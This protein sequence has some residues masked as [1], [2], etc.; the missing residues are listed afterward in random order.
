[1][2]LQI[3][4]PRDTGEFTRPDLADDPTRQLNPPPRRPNADPLAATAEISIPRTIGI[5]APFEPDTNPPHPI[6]FPAP[7]GPHPRVAVAMERIMRSGEFPVLRPAVPTPELYAD[8]RAR[9]GLPPLRR[10]R[11]YV[12][13]H[14]KA[15]AR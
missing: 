10:P 8:M 11:G 6:P 13:R 3:L 5:V 4:D 9:R 14:R 12:G 2:T 15:G 1:M 7:A